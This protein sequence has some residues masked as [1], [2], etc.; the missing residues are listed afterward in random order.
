MSNGF[1]EW[2][3]TP[4]GQYV[5]QWEKA[6]Y[7][8]L[9]ADI[10]GFKAVQLGLT[11]HDFL[12][13]NRMPFRFHCD[14]KSSAR[15]GLIAKPHFLP[16]ANA[17]VDLVILPH[18]LEFAVT[19]HQILREVERVLVPEGQVV[20]TGF[21]PF[22]LWGVRRLFSRRK[23]RYGLPGSIPWSGQYL[24][25]M[26]L[27]DWF[28][29]LGFETHAGSFGCYAPPVS[30]SLQRWR[31]LELAGNRWWPYAG[32]TYIIQA[33]KRVHGMRLITPVRHELM[34]RAKSL[35]TVTQNTTRTK[36]NERNT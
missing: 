2:L 35:A 16:F 6:Q 11:Q 8:L 13:A 30:Q 7:D 23:T 27:R 9:V 33:I 25:V 32:A 10:F 4:Q 12:R 31:L 22:S 26:R 20:V 17:S 29:L 36:N 28:A 34:A 15:A 21:N 1:D 3:E 19:P 24:S 5:L 14:D 18:V